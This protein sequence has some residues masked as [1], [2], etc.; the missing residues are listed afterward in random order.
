MSNKKIGKS[1]L[2]KGRKKKLIAVGFSL[3][4]PWQSSG[5]AGWKQCAFV[6]RAPAVRVVGRRS[7]YLGTAEPLRTTES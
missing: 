4:L 6:L 3:F 1:F 2:K 7:L 5:N